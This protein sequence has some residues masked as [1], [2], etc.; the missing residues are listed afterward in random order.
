MKTVNL[1][2]KRITLNESLTLAKESAVRILT[3]NGHA[4][5]REDESDLEK[6]VQILDKSKK[7]RR[8]LKK[9]SKEPATTSL[10]DYRKSLD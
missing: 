8:F 6:E 2:H 9:R 7:F 1:A 5:A 4:L 10:D 3:A